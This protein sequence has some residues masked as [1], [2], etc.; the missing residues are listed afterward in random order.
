VGLV[1]LLEGMDHRS[2]HT[3]LSGISTKLRIPGLMARLGLLERIRL[4]PE[5]I[6]LEEARRLTMTMFRRG[7][8]LFVLSY[9]SSSLLPGGA[10]YVSTQAELRTFLAWLQGYLRF[11]FGPLSGRPATADT[12][13][14]ALRVEAASSP[15][16]AVA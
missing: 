10:P 9:H 14:R 7:H 8:R 4:T 12:I 1:G 11:F 16:M 5:G 3:L 15:A 13:Y 6:S 2:V